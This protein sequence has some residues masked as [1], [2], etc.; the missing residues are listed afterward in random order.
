MSPG[1]ERPILVVGVRRTPSCP[2]VCAVR[3]LSLLS[4]LASLS[5][6]TGRPDWG[7]SLSARATRTLRAGQ[8]EAH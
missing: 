6:M 3:K 8:L 5:C 7:V 1:D 2:A 4:S